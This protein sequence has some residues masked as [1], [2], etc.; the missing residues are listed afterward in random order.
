[1]TVS[2][3]YHSGVAFLRQHHV[4]DAAFDC[5]CLAQEIFSLSVGDMPSFCEKV[6]SEAAFSRYE[7]VLR[8]RAAGEPLQYLI[9]SW[10]FYDLRFFVG[11]GV[12]IPRPETEMLVE[13]ALSVL[14]QRP[15]AVVYDLCAGSGCIGLTIAAHCPQC[16]VFLFEKSETALSYLNRSL[17]SLGLTNAKPIRYDITN[18]FCGLSDVPAADLL[19]SNPPYIPS[20]E[21]AS[22]QKEVQCEPKMALDGGQDGLD[23]YRVLADG[24]LPYLNKSAFAAVETAENQPA[25]VQK[26]FSPVLSHIRIHAD[27]CGID[28]FVS[29]TKGES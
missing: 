8:R 1:M 17:A 3:A 20:G 4:D 21:L 11:P 16:Q 5:R 24:W 19:L 26:I 27:C 14:S 15:D 29:G 7:Q 2:Q 22:L 10:D 13:L 18:D 6:I 25:G 12:L 23:F 28:R 9:G